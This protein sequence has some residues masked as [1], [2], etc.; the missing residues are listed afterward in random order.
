MTKVVPAILTGN[1]ELLVTMVR[2]AETFADYLQ[3]DIMDGRF[4]P[5]VSITSEHL[6]SLSI[7]VNWEVHLMVEHPE[8]Y[9][10]SFKEAGTRKIIFHY[11]ATN[12]H[13]QVIAHTR[14]QGLSVGLAINPETP[15]SAVKELISDVDSLLL[16]TVH[17]G[18]YG[19]QFL[20][21]VMKKI[22]VIRNVRAGMEIGVDGGIKEN[23]ILQVARLGV[24]AINVGSAIFLE[25]K[26]A[27]SYRK[28]QNI[29][30][31]YQH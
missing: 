27:E 8:D 30:T 11:E 13:Q 4:V 31:N 25:P 3:V 9:V 1:P 6:A 22:P 26:P 19:S 12:K 24:D 2:Q 29:V 7:K 5:S 17:P 15:V 20:P 21:E 18:Y 23:N 16:L 14:N 10:A 28:L